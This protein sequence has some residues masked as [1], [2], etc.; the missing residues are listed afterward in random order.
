M[1]LGLHKVTAYIESG[2][3]PSLRLYRARGFCEEGLLRDDLWMNG[4][5][6]DRRVLALF[7]DAYKMP[8]GMLWEDDAP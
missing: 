4:R 7:S 1:T 2:N 3:E 8:D 6:V 5:Y